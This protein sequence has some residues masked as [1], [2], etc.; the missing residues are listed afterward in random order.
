MEVSNI[1][2]SAVIGK[3]NVTPLGIGQLLLE[4][5][6][7]MQKR[8][9]KT[10]VMALLIHFPI[11]CHGCNCQP[12]FNRWLTEFIPNQAEFDPHYVWTFG[13]NERSPFC[14][15][16][17]MALMLDG[18]IAKSPMEHCNAARR[19]WAPIIDESGMIHVWPTQSLLSFNNENEG[20]MLPH[21]APRSNEI[22]TDAFRHLSW[23]G[24][25]DAQPQLYGDATYGCSSV[26]RMG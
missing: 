10:L 4:R 17:R 5:M 9:P 21:D 7:F 13:T 1:N 11:T 14:W 19:H 26:P 12:V 25:L 20:F 24:T 22:F 18:N 16:C 8:H 6:E 2:G 23:I 15:Q 3:D